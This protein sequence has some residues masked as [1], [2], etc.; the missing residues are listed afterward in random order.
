MIFFGEVRNTRSSGW[1]GVRGGSTKIS[2]KD[3]WDNRG[4]SAQ[5]AR[6]TN[7]MSYDDLYFDNKDDAMNVLTSMDEIVDQ[8]GVVT[9]ADLFDLAGV[10]GNG[11]TDQNYGWTS[12]NSA[13][14]VRGRDGNFY[15]KLQRPMPIK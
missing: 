13:E 7:R 3:C 12:T 2:Y 4:R 15:L 9:V 11:Y 5:P 1:G 10:T 6:P 14:V 8:Y